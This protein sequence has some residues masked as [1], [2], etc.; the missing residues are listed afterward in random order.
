VAFDT[1]RNTP[2]WRSTDVT[3][4]PFGSV[5]FKTSASG[6][7]ANWA[8]KRYNGTINE[9]V[10]QTAPSRH[11]SRKKKKVTQIMQLAVT[12]EDTDHW[13]KWIYR[14]AF[15]PHIRTRC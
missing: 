11:G 7:G 8:V 4:R 14:M 5:W 15:V 12:Y 2:A 1:F 6:Q 3:A 13:I 10:L 9:W